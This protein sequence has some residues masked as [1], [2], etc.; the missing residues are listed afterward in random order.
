MHA[1]HRDAVFKPHELGQ[2]LGAL[3]DRDLALPRFH[4]FG[5]LLVDGGTGHHHPG[6][7]HIARPHGPRKTVAPRL[8]SR[9]V[10]LDWRRSEPETA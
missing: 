9:S 7:N 10:M 2:H 5:V 8:P 1:G 3:D 4:H 6:A